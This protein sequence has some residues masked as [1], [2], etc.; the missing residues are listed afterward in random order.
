MVLCH[1]GPGGWDDL[2][3]V[4]DMVD[5]LV[6]VHRYDQRACGRSS[7]GPPFDV[8][9]AVADLDALR[10]H[11]NIP[12]WIVGGESWGAHLALYYSLAHPLHVSALI[13][14]AGAGLVAD[15]YPGWRA[16][17]KENER[18]F[19]S[20]EEWQ[21]AAEL[22]ALRDRAQGAAFTQLD[23]AYMELTWKIGIADRARADEL[24]QSLLSG[25]LSLNRE[26][27]Q[28]L[29]EDHLRLLADVSLRTRLRTLRVPA[30]VVHGDTDPR[31]AWALGRLAE[32]IP[33]G[34]LVTLPEVGHIL[35]LERP[36]LLRETLRRYFLTIGLC[37]RPPA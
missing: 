15:D 6:T 23:R 24:V 13:Y 3:P 33:N 37:S 26:V 30:L 20:P 22:R 29:G 14:M 28:V 27:N 16:E 1:G 35:W 10:R 4:A 31:P 12:R 18:T 7:G 19:L 5:D 11:W 34:Q 9:T 8:A 32:L 17:F 2:G 36:H 21:R 25:G